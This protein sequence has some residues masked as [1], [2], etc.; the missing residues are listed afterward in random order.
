M[1][2]GLANVE[3][4]L[5]QLLYHFDWTLPHGTKPS[6]MDMADAEGIA[7]GRK[8]NLLVIPTPYNPYA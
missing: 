8:H 2:F 7:V 6:D 4:P 3:L 5:A 1:T